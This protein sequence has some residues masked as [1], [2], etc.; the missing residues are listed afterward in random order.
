MIAILVLPLLLVIASLNTTFL[1]GVVAVAA[2]ALRFIVPLLLIALKVPVPSV[3][4]GLPSLS[5]VIVAPAIF[6]VNV[7]L[8]SRAI[9]FVVFPLAL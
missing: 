3:T 2:A 8:P 9:I 1:S 6:P 7:E 4:T 5:S